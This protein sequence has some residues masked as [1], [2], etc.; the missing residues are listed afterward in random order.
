MVSYLETTFVDFL[1]N[2]IHFLS[3]CQQQFCSFMLY[4]V[5]QV[6]VYFVNIL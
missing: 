1:K 2:Y 3:C 4:I 6:K 5:F